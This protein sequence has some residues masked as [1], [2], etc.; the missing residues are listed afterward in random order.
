MK[1]SD[2][3][4]NNRIRTAIRAVEAESMKDFAGLISGMDLTS[5]SI[6][7]AKHIKAAMAVIATRSMLGTAPLVALKTEVKAVRKS[8]IG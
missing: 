1:F 7:T 6:R 4:I 3:S 2:L 5:V 8:P